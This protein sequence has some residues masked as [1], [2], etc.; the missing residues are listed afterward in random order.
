MEE[1]SFNNHLKNSFNAI[2][3]KYIIFFIL[4]LLETLSTT[5]ATHF[6]ISMDDNVILASALGSVFINVILTVVALNTFHSFFN[7]HKLSLRKSFWD[8]PTYIFYELSF[9]LLTFFGL[10]L[11]IFPGIYIFYF[12][13]FAP[14]VSIIFD[15]E[16]DYDEGIF[17]KTKLLV[18]TNLQLYTFILIPFGL[19]SVIDLVFDKLFSY[20]STDIWMS[21]PL[22]FFVCFLAVVSLGQMISFLNSALKKAFPTNNGH[23]AMASE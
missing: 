2:R 10:V 18:S 16:N 20:I 21:L 6:S 19:L 4:I 1:L 7:G 11:L 13:G 22:R 14:V 12:L 9:G 15:D 3:S 8:I 23:S 17:K 5:T